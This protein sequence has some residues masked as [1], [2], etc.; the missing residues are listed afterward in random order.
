M[1]VLDLI[2]EIRTGHNSDADRLILN[3]AEQLVEG[4]WEDVS[5]L[6]DKLLVFVEQRCATASPRGGFQ[7]GGRSRRLDPPGAR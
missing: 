1:G 6:E 3:A 4:I 7:R 2:G 5:D